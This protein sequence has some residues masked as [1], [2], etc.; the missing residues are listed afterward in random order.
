M[1]II[2]AIPLALLAV[3]GPAE[4][5]TWN[6][7]PPP[8]TFSDKAVLDLR[9]LNER[10]A[11][12]KGFVRLSKDG[13][14][15]VLGDG[16]PVRFWAYNDNQDFRRR[17][18]RPPMAADPW[19]ADAERNARFLAKRGLNLSRCFINITPT[20][21]DI[22][23]IAEDERDVLWR[24]VATMKK[25]GIYTLFTPYWA[26]SSRVHPG[27]GG[28]A[29]TGDKDKNPAPYGLLFFDPALKKAYKAWMKATLTEKNP[30]TGIPLAQDPALAVIQLQ[31]E[32]GLFW[33]TLNHPITGDAGRELGKQF[34]TWLAKQHGSVN[35]AVARWQGA[36]V[37]GDDLAAGTP[38]LMPIWNM[39][40]LGAGGAGMDARRCDQAAF[41]TETTRSFNAEMTAYLRDDLGCKQLIS[42]GNWYS[43]A[44][45]LLNDAQRCADAVCDVVA[46]NRYFWLPVTGSQ[47]TGWAVVDGDTF[48]DHSVLED[49][50]SFPLALKHVEGHPMITTEIGWMAPLSHRS[51]SSLLVAAYG[52]LTGFDAPCWFAN[53]GEETWR[54]PV[55]ANGYIK[56]QAR[57]DWATPMCLGQWPATALLFRK[58]L[59]R[60]GEPVVRER[61]SLSD[62]T[63]MRAPIIA[64]RSG[65][66]PL[67]DK[68]ILSST[69]NITTPVDEH[70]YLVGPVS[71]A[72]GADPASSV[73]AKDLGSHLDLDRGQARSD[74]GELVWNWK[75]GLC[76]VDAPRA[77]GATGFL[78]KR[79]SIALKDLTI[80]CRNRY[81]T[82][83]A[84]SLDDQP[85]ANSTKVL[86]QVGTTQKPTGWQTRPA[87]LKGKPGT[88]QG[89]APTAEEVVALGQ[90]PWQVEEA[91]ITIAI[92]NPRLAKVRT[93]DANLEEV[94]VGDLDRA[95][96]K[97][98]FTFPKS[99]LYVLLTE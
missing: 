49:P 16:T 83:I 54:P 76:T 14:D 59:V 55:S 63:S 72:Y 44:S 96:G 80:A 15:F 57:Y 23:A 91:D 70:A 82:I 67:R 68:E 4:D 32:D 24:E 60:Q 5:R 74:T 48:L 98:S 26:L 75:D 12:E 30:Y 9:S 46:V 28:V 17:K 36:K 85:L 95:S 79:D 41:L 71:V 3:A 62:I 93:L 27:Q 66:D 51:E 89:N 45:G 52:C 97:G 22:D 50:L 78:A 29:A 61:R 25:Q 37:E 84:V 39:I 92:A 65:S 81:A 64:E 43:V 77:Q 53:M 2:S 58:G 1:R 47:T 38:A 19:P 86:V 7:D 73:V 69:S 40:S 56:S 90:P 87:K 11:G 34:G 8:D 99:A 6:F 88:D 21:D 35:D 10:E 18:Q 94:S 13:N 42:A 33:W 20:G 31:N